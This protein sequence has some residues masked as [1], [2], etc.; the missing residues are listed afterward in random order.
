MDSI[1]IVCSV[2]IVASLLIAPA[3]AFTSSDESPRGC[4]YDLAY[5]LRTGRQ[6]GT[7]ISVGDDPNSKTE[8]GQEYWTW[9]NGQT[10]AFEATLDGGS[11]SL[12]LGDTTA[13]Y[14]TESTG[15]VNTLKLWA[16]THG[17]GDEPSVDVTDIVID[18]QT[19]HR[20]LHRDYLHEDSEPDVIWAYPIDATDGLT[21]TG[22][23]T[24]AWTGGD[25]PATS[26]MEFWIETAD[27]LL[28]DRD[29]DG[30]SDEHELAIGSS[31]RHVDSD[32]D[33]C[34]DYDEVMVYGTQPNDPDTDGDLWSDCLEIAEGSSPTNPLSFPHPSMGPITLSEDTEG[35]EIPVLDFLAPIDLFYKTL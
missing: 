23:V 31:P 12:R 2:A 4:I 6:G 25:Q 29:G 14:T 8:S 13:Y 21:V 28:G 33:G 30:L 10:V 18:G 7:Q 24:F 19:A 9:T 32:R 1:R 35:L 5:Q 26:R 17:T 15:F 22:N 16:K 3:M 34:D 11:M 20:D 27:C